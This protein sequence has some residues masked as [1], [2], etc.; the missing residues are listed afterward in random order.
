MSDNLIGADL[1]QYHITESIGHG[2]MATVYKA[3]QSA[4]DRFVAIKVLPHASDPQFA[5][6]FKIEAR[7]LAR[8]QHPNILPIYDYGE[9]NHLL[10]LVLQYIENGVTLAEILGRPMPPMVALRI[11]SQILSAMEYAH[12]HNVIH[13]DIK[14][15]NILM[16]TPNW[17]ML[18]DF[19]IAKLLN[20]S[21]YQLTTPGLIMGT[22][23][24]MS[25]EQALGQEVDAR[26]DLYALG[27]VLYEMMTGRVPFDTGTPVLV[28]T[29]HAYEAP[30]PPRKLNPNL[31]ETI[32]AVLLRALEKDPAA[33]FQSAAE[34]AEAFEQ[35]TQQLS[36]LP[37]RIQLDRLYR[38]GEQALKEQRWELAV[39]HL[40]QLVALDP[41]YKDGLDLLRAARAA[42]QRRMTSEQ[43]TLD[44]DDRLDVLPHDSVPSAQQPEAL[45][46]ARMAPLLDSLAHIV[47]ST[48]PVS[49]GKLHALLAAAGLPAAPA[50]LGEL[51]RWG[52]LLTSLRERPSRELRRT[53][54]Q[55]LLD[56]GLPEPVVTAA[57]SAIVSSLS[58]PTAAFDTAPPTHASDLAQAVDQ[59]ARQVEFGMDLPA[60]EAMPRAP[61]PAEPALPPFV[62]GLP[63]P[64]RQRLVDD[65]QQLQEFGYVPAVDPEPEGVRLSCELPRRSGM[66]Y[67]LAWHCSMVYPA[68]PPKLIVVEQGFDDYGQIQH[69]QLT[70]MLPQLNRWNAGIALREVLH[71]IERQLENDQ[72]LRTP[73]SQVG[74]GPTPPAP[75]PEL[76]VPPLAGPG[77]QPPPWPVAPQPE[78]LP[79]PSAP[80]VMPDIASLPQWDKTWQPPAPPAP[81]PHPG[82]PR[83]ASNIRLLVGTIAGVAVLLAL[84][85][86]GTSLFARTTPPAPPATAAAAATSS[87]PQ[88]TDAGATILTTATEP[89]ASPPATA[90]PAS[91]SP[92]PSPPKACIGP[93]ALAGAISCFAPDIETLLLQKGYI[94]NQASIAGQNRLIASNTDP[95]AGVW[96]R[97][98][99]YA[100]SG[101][102]YVLDDMAVLRD[103]IAL[104]LDGI[105]TN[106][107]APEGR[108]SNQQKYVYGE[109]WDSAPNLIHAT[110]TYIAKT[111][112]RGFYQEHRD[113]LQQLGA[114]IAALDTDDD[115]LPDRDIFPYGYYNSVRNSVQHTYALAKFYVAFKDLAE[116]ERYTEHDGGAWDA[117]ARR[118]R[119]GFHRPFDQGGYWR[120]DQ[121]WPIAWRRPDGSAVDVLETFGVFEALRAGLIAP[122]DGAHY[123]RLVAALHANLPRLLDG[124]APVR[125]ALG[126]Y[127]PELR[128]DIVPEKEN[129]KLDASAPWIVGI[130]APAYAAAGYPDDARMIMQAYLDM[131]NSAGVPRLAAG[132][133]DR[134]G[135]GKEGGG[136]AWDRAAWF[137]A[138][139]GGHYGLTLTPDA[140]VVQPRPFD[141]TRA[142]DGI[143]GL[144]YQGAA[145]E[146]SL[147]AMQ[148]TYSIRASQPINVILRPVGAAAQVR[149]DGGPPQDQAALRLEP[150]HTYIVVSVG[151]P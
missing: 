128:R 45:S 82:R 62:D 75:P 39:E 63:S 87:E 90:A 127:A 111:G 49:G 60:A 18:A 124:P 15:T 92:P 55:A 144:Q 80:F 126:G 107:V 91:T 23:A 118:L 1:G 53:T 79:V 120:D 145:I 28:L 117:R 26:T 137:Q 84:V 131:A 116:L 21:Q 4:L 147:D 132:Q 115:G 114:W 8:L 113:A 85:F 96:A 135:A 33:R 57:V 46:I 103:S 123:Q 6:R 104:L 106:G 25:P 35:A 77:T 54:M 130:A 10:Y 48:A 149:V 41:N 78:P 44:T 102:S 43:L 2:G 5:S 31:P 125:L 70:F 108:F 61:A 52:E 51:Q 101:Y 105:D 74:P 109:T 150:D 97:D 66:S 17:P 139:Y 119:V 110:Y 136:G 56:R 86:V 134:Y 30:P 151:Q 138:V 133:N 89:I 64:L 58:M 95:I 36:P 40:S 37:A 93:P 148:K 3:Y 34:M 143:R 100:T 112:D 19:G 73:V 14:P 42:Q 13:R 32:E 140:L 11:I 129:W 71:T 24:Y 68:E 121:D 50:A 81:V 99:D 16:P 65:Y 72:F 83:A 69:N 98:L 59:P 122:D 29:R 94:D 12:R 47:I 20:E 38:D 22:A 7:T 141:Q 76:V 146:L 67:S 9:S 88:A 27:V 142:A